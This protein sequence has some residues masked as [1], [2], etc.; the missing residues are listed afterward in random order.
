MIERWL[1]VQRYIR[2]DSGKVKVK[3]NNGSSM[4]KVKLG[5]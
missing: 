5:D 1:K 3:L 2:D 4:V